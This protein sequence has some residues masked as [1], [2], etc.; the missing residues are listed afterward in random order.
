MTEPPRLKVDLSGVSESLLWN[1]YQRAAEAR[2]PDAVLRDPKAVELVESIDYPFEE[3]FGKGGL[4]QWQALRVLRFDQEVAS[5]L[6]DHPDGQVV[7]LGEGLETQFWR[8]DNGRVRWLGVDVPD[9]VQLR[10]QIL[11][12]Q[13][14]RQRSLGCSALSQEWMEQVDPAHGLLLTAQGLLMYFQPG[15][16]H[17][18]IA[19][20][21]RRFPGA[22]LVFDG[23]PPW[24]SQ[25]T[26]AGKMTTSGGYQS[27]PMPWAIDAAEKKRLRAIPNVAE[28]GDL[29]PPRGRGLLRGHLYPLLNRSAAVREM[30]LTG[31]PLHRMR[32]GHTP[33]SD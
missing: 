32:F 5:F 30:G 3:K 4:G 18:L 10:G 9:I 6:A 16:V 15:E 25:R 11:P 20:L 17:E 7:A 29:L 23:V 12:D 2:R 33:T 31:L 28:V 13:A 8:V 21:A 26:L 22:T 14:P 27:P 1:L 24:F 19:T